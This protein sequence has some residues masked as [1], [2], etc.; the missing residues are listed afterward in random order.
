MRMN[1]TLCVTGR[2]YQCRT[3]ADFSK[4]REPGHEVR[5]PA[6][7]SRVVVSFEQRLSFGQRLAFGFQIEANVFVG[8]VDAHVPQPMGDRAEIDSRT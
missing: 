1:S 6:P 5:I 7:F 4:G 8:S 3:V 2:R